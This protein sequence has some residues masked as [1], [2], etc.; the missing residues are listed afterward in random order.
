MTVT[1]RETLATFAAAAFRGTFTNAAAEPSLGGE[2]P[3]G[4]EG[5]YFPFDAPVADLRPDGSPARDGVLP[6]FDL[7]RRMYAGEDTVFHRPLR[8]GEVVEQVARRGDVVEKQG[9]GGRLVFADVVR[10]YR[11]AGELA[12][13]S[14]WHDVFLETTPPSR[15]GAPVPAES[16]DWTEEVRLD[17]RQLFRFSALTFNT[18]RVHFDRDWARGAEGLTDLLV[19]GPL[20]R[21]LLLDAAVRHDPGSRVHAFTFRAQAPIFVD[22]TVSIGGRRNG[23]TTDVHAVDAT[24]NLLAR[25]RVMWGPSH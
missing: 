23:D 22:T 15:A 20:T 13:E 17:S 5:L 14:T 7:P 6:E 10:E 11:V 8:Y 9:R 2:L 19:H 4:W 18:H 1:R 21:V 12:I 25:G 3:P 24:G 16:P